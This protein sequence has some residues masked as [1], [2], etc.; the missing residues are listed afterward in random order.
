MDD[1]QEAEGSQLAALAPRLH[2]GTTSFFRL[3]AEARVAIV[4][5][6]GEPDKVPI[7]ASSEAGVDFRGDF[8]AAARCTAAYAAMELECHLK[9]ILPAETR[10][11]ICGPDFKEEAADLQIRL[12]VRGDRRPPGSFLITPGGDVLH[13]VGEDRN[14]LLYAVYALLEMQ[15]WRWLMPGS[16]GAVQPPIEDGLWLPDSRVK[17]FPAFSLRGFDFVFPSQESAELLVWMARNRLNLAGSRPS[18]TALGRKLGM[19]YKDGGH[20]FEEI[21][22]PDRALP[23]G[24]T[25]WEAHPEWYGIPESGK[26]IKEEALR[27]QFCVS[28]PALLDFLGEELV[29]RLEGVWKEADLVSVWG[30][31]TW[32][33]SCTCADCRALG[34]ASDQYMVLMARL[35][36]A[37]DQ[38]LA[39]GRLDRPVRMSGCAYEGTC[40]LEGP[41]GEIPERLRQAGDCIIFYPIDRSYAADLHDPESPVNRRYAAALASWLQREDSLPVLVGEYYN[42]SKYEDLPLL[43]SRRIPAD[44]RSYRRHGVAGMTYMHLPF[45]NWALRSQTQWLYGR[46]NWDPEQE[47]A[48]LLYAYFQGRYGPWAEAMAAVYEDIGSAMSYIGEWRNWHGSFLRTLM[49]W[50]GRRPEEPLKLPNGLG[51]ARA[52]IAQGLAALDKLDRALA[53]LVVLREREKDRLAEGAVHECQEAENPAQLGDLSADAPIDHALGEDWRLLRYGRET[54][55]LLTAAVDYHRALAEDEDR[56]AD[57]AWDAMRQAGEA[58]EAMWIPIA[59]TYPEPGLRG[60]DGL[61]RSQLGAVLLRCRAARMEKGWRG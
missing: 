60:L 23:D 30:F 42:V 53:Q 38:A 36:E 27:T 24:R 51:T 49:A 11:E 29:R 18:T 13:L 46:Y 39:A 7:C 54:M 47:T 12:E 9:L 33:S 1:L 58:L 21:L 52:A 6:F 19:V 2:A 17:E 5:P 26:Q 15:G 28:Q 57:S 10:V 31:D 55:A 4:F 45:V 32:G 16:G 50:D 34:N 3:G 41:L 20:I 8:Q 56:A 61:T 35:R 48:P 40:T 43:F 59:Y 44:L 25:L 14:G 22:D 37:I